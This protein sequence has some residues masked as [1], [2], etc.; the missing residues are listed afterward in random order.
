MVKI[1]L[2]IE[3]LMDNMSYMT[4]ELY[5]A[6]DMLLKKIF[7][8][9]DALEIPNCILAGGTA[10]ARYYLNHRISYDL[11]FFV[12]QDFL[13][14]RLAINLGREGFRLTDLHLE[15]DGQ[16][17]SQ[18]HAQTD[19]E[20]ESIKISFVADI[21]DGMW[22]KVTFD[23]VMTEE[24]GG[25]YHRKL[26]TISGNQTHQ[27][28]HQGGRQKARDLFDLFVLNKEIKPIHAFIDEANLHGANFPIDAFS[29]HLISMPWMNL[30]SEFENLERLPPFDH[31]IFFMRD[32]KDSLIKEA[33]TLQN[34]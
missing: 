7:S 24:I 22:N 29:A 16:W 19:I 18:L 11:D 32:I 6:Q 28:K 25:L 17:T 31:G 12:G 30:I 14:E 8:N 21:Y 5:K 4:L 26:R 34:L 13:P 2:L 27:G 3:S 15:H 1:S 23:P 9:L 10:L 20:G 33:L